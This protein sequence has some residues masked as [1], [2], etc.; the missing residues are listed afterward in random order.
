[1]G[2][3][4]W[5]WRRRQI[6]RDLDDE[7]RSHFEMAIAD[8]VAGGEDP[9]AAR[10]HAMKDFGNVLRTTENT[11]SVWRGRLAAS[12]IDLGQDVRFGVRM[13]RKNS[14]FSLV[15]IFVLT[16][17]IAGNAAVFS[18]FKGLALKPLPGVPGSS[19][20]AVI[21]GRT[22]DGRAI[23]LSLPDYRYFKDHA[24]AFEHLTA[25][26][27]VFASVGLGT[28]AQRVVAELVTG[29]YFE[30][31]GVNAQ[32]GRTL[33]P[34]DDIA[35]GQHPVAVIS[36]VLWRSTFHSDPQVVGK[37]LH[38]NGQP[39]TIVGVTPPDF[40][41]TVVG[42]GID[43]FA[44]I[45][46]QPQVWPPNRLASR[47]VG[48]M[49]TLGRLRAGQTIASAGAEAD[50]LGSQLEAEAPIPNFARHISVVPIFQ[51]PFGAQTYWLPTVAVLGGMGLLILLVVCAN[52]ANLVLVR[53][54]SRGGELAVRL[55]L[56][57]SRR[58]LLRLLFVENMMLA[59]PGALAGVAL[60]SL[61]LPFVAGGAST[62]A[63]TRIYLDTT[64]DGYVIVFA[65]TLSFACALVF[66]FVPALRTS[67]VNLTSLMNDVSPRMASR[68]RLRAALVVS[69]V[70]MSLVLLVVAGLMLRSYAAAQ[71]ADGGFDAHNVTSVSIDL[72]TAG[73]TD[74]TGP[75]VIARL[76]DAIESEPAFDSASLAFIA[77]MSLVDSGPRAISVEGY[78]PRADEDMIFLSN[79]VGPTYFSTLR[80]PLAAGR[81]FMRTDDDDAAPV[82]IINETLA[83]R[84][85]Q[86]PRN[87]IGKRLRSG[88]TGAWRTVIG[89]ARDV[90][91]SRLSEPPRPYVYFPLLQDYLPGFI[92]HA[93]ATGDV[94]GAMRR[95]RL[96]VNA[97]DPAIPIMRAT[98]LQEQTR[99]A[100]TVYQLGAGALTM[101]GALT[102]ILAAI[103]IYGLVAYSVKQSTQEIGIR[104][105]VGASRTNVMLAFLRR[106]TGLAAIGAITGLAL[107]LAISR[108]IH[109]LLY[110]VT[111]YDAL[112]FGGATII[113]MTI[114]LAASIFP[115]W[116][117]SKTDPLTALRHR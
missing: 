95:L 36:D 117:A 59:V 18:L 70:A 19:Q 10:L 69:Q 42:M 49:M 22:A 54:I 89:V 88:S 107:A 97:V 113:V 96:H 71:R 25:A 114:A 32:L 94:A 105:A 46:V 84:M 34:S 109:S 47:G 24:H 63:P 44:P 21:L 60:A 65:L 104:M 51:S 58:R 64:V 45:M 66:G 38:L 77:P 3:F 82:A 15:V 75:V 101:F 50:V 43:V 67:R 7:I 29:N 1:M 41:G 16:L 111:A 92:I 116:S 4:T 90:K 103:G 106:G 52:V 53:G 78:S 27:M 76:L 28:D 102:I 48:M 98:T 56:G 33:L 39:L 13:L 100:L 6:E 93:R 115:A 87:A 86:T 110:G 40:N 11:R 62:G 74:D 37:T 8:R 5:L 83:R 91:Y 2:L 79:I 73:Y 9:E 99:V 68:G 31:L 30:A 61:A 17:G 85:W 20:L 80:I 112:A 108:S 12:V 35:P 81:D 14:G 23:G 26:A 57:A 72:Q 55:A